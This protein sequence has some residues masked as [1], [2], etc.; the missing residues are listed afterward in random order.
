MMNINNITDNTFISDYMKYMQS[1]ETATAYDFW[2]A[3]W[4]IAFAMGRRV[5]VQRPRAPVYM[6]WYM[7]LC[8]DSGI[9]R[10]SSAISSAQKI[11]SMYLQ[12]MTANKKF[13]STIECTKVIPEKWMNALSEMTKKYNKAQSAL[14]I[15][16]MATAFGRER[17]MQGLPIML[18]DLYDCP[19]IMDS[20]GS[21]SHG[22]VT[23]KNVFIMLLTGST[24]SWLVRAINPDVIEGGFTSRCL[25]ITSNKRKKAI[26]WPTATD[27]NMQQQFVEQLYAL[28]NKCPQDITITDG[29]LDAFTRWYKARRTYY[30]A[31]RSSFQSREDSHVLRLAAC[32]CIN[33]GSFVINY[34]HIRYAITL[35]EDVREQ[36]ASLFE[37]SNKDTIMIGI[38]KIIGALIDVGHA[39]IV[40]RDLYTKVRTYMTNDEFHTAINI[41]HEL[42]MLQIFE[43]AKKRIY[44]GT[45]NITKDALRKQLTEQLT[46]H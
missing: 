39:G 5:R 14:I 16:E 34:N 42:A 8:A 26:A 6:N 2:T 32:L 25:F 11:A 12:Y 4:L 21:F 20:S 40:H 10:K 17:Y 7:I 37:G 46:R 24:S 19:S 13:H 23:L 33:D 41:M 35:I 28:F 45:T 29:G 3:I 44:R 27:N 38:H 36:G 43:D 15:S 9:T 31:Y 1:Q 22:S 18:T 30:D